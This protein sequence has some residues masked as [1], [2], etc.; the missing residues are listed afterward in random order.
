LV[1][2]LAVENPRVVDSVVVFELITMWGCEVTGVSMVV[3]LLGA[4]MLGVE[5]EPLVVVKLV[6]V[7]CWGVDGASVSLVAEVAEMLRLGTEVG[8]SELKV[9]IVVDELVGCSPPVGVALVIVSVE[10]VES[11]RIVC[12]VV[13]TCAGAF[14][15]ESSAAT[16]NTRR[17]MMNGFES[18]NT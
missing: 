1:V 12:V 5:A 10:L 9:L 8:A 14:G 17:T 11:L 4:I 7:D 2:R 13:K 16:V 6:V 3:V 15:M 18:F